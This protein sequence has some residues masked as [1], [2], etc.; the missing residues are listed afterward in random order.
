[1]SSEVRSANQEE[2]AK[3]TGR[4]DFNL[5]PPVRPSDDSRK[6]C[7][8]TTYI[9]MPYDVRT[10]NVIS[11]NRVTFLS[12]RR[13]QRG[14]TCHFNYLFRVSLGHSQ[15]SERRVLGVGTHFIVQAKT[16]NDVGDILPFHFIPESSMRLSCLHS[17][18]TLVS[19]VDDLVPGYYCHRKPLSM[20]DCM[21]R[22]VPWTGR[23]E[24][25]RIR[26]RS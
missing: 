9:M 16:Q 25:P 22:K 26:Y 10:R 24:V 2:T 3:G 17:S 13:K 23:S 12:K 19:E 7:H 15:L 8:S 18:F 14:Y 20:M 5:I 21:A 1:M 6:M 11:T 4:T